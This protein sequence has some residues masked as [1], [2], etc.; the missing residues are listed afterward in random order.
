MADRRLLSPAKTLSEGA[1]A[2][3]EPSYDKKVSICF[4]DL[5]VKNRDANGASASEVA[6]E[7]MRRGWLSPLD[8]VIDIADIMAE[9]AG[10]GKL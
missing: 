3:A 10:S 4:R 5:C 2:T 6:R 7:M 9:L 1:L 8:T